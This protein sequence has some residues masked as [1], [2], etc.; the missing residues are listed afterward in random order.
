[1]S[2]SHNP[3]DDNGGKFYDERG[4]QPVPPDDQIMADLV[5]QVTAI[6][7]L[8]WSEALRSGRVHLLDETPHRA[9]LDLLRRQ[10]LVPPPKFDEIQVVFTPLHGV[11][12][13]TA[14]EVLVA[15]G[16]RVTP[17]AEQQ[18]PDGQFPNVTK[19]PNPEVP[20]SM[21]RAV[22]TARKVNA[23]LALATD[24]DADRLG[25]MIPDRQGGWRLVTGHRVAP[26]LTPL[27]P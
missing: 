3:P 13:M 23:D 7:T 21:D 14:M 18:Q 19:T 24:P 15:Q 26:L 5:D 1:I 25:A 2:A 22:A 17:V 6:K 8:P 16:F 20:E 12:G 9:Y 10:S 4:G 11:G 27:Q